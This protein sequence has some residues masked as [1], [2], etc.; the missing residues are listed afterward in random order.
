MSELHD[1]NAYCTA[2]VHALL[3]TARAGVTLGIFERWAESYGYVLHEA[4]RVVEVDLATEQAKRTH[5]WDAD[6]GERTPY[7]LTDGLP[8]DEVWL[9][10]VEVA[11]R[12]RSAAVGE[13]SYARKGWAWGS[14]WWRVR[15]WWK[16]Q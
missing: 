16:R 7:L 3:L 15:A 6:T 9:V 5:H 2:D 8:T 12:V 13:E 14:A 1:C 4:R 11:Q 10:R